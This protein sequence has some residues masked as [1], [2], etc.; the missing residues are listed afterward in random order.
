[1]KPILIIIL[2]LLLFISSFLIAQEKAIISVEPTVTKSIKGISEL[3]RKKYFNISN[4][5]TDFESKIGNTEQ[6]NY[7]L[8]DL[9]MTFGRSLGGV[10]SEWQWGNPIFQD[11]N[12]AGFVTEEFDVIPGDF[13]CRDFNTIRHKLTEFVQILKL[14]RIDNMVRIQIIPSQLRGQHHVASHIVSEKNR[15]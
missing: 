7:Y 11:H 10:F 9:D 14:P 12:H 13:A 2:T 5:G 4:P 8:D 3:D 1:M 6:V 15:R